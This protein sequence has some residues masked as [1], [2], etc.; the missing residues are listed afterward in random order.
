MKKFLVIG[1]LVLLAAPAFAMDGRNAVNQCINRGPACKYKV[2]PNGTIDIFVDGHII[3]CGSD[4]E[5]C[6]MISRKKG[7]TGTTPIAPG[8]TPDKL[9]AG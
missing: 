5:E 6:I 7:K 3:W 8:T 1:C 9:L 4:T 2:H